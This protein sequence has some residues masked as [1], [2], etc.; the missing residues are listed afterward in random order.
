MKLNLTSAARIQAMK[1]VFFLIIQKTL[2]LNKE[3]R[4]G[5]PYNPHQQ[6]YFLGAVHIIVSHL[7]IDTIFIK[8]FMTK[9]HIKK[10]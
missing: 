2:L 1:V 3:G 4:P 6:N 9:Q 7:D 8:H 10:L 5:S